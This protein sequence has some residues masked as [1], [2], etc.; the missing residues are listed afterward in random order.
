MRLIIWF[1]LRYVAFQ[2]FGIFRQEKQTLKT[3]KMEI[4]SALVGSG[5]DELNGFSGPIGDE[6]LQSGSL[7][8]AGDDED[9]D[10]EDIDDDDDD[11]DDDDFDDDDDDDDDEDDKFDLEEDLS[12]PA[13]DDDDDDEGFYDDQFWLSKTV[14]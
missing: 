5:S 4:S 12:D 6:K 13:F 14:Y 11:F 2:I 10:D 7:L 8:L 9:L 1:S 3:Q